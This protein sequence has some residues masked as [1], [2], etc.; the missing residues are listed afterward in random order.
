MN[1]L[2]CTFLFTNQLWYNFVGLI[3]KNEKCFHNSKKS[4]KDYAENGFKNFR[5]GF[6][7]VDILK[8]S[9]LYIYALVLF[10]VKNLN[11]Y[12]THTS[13]H[14]RNARLQN[15]LHIPSVKL[16]SIQTGVSYSSITIFDQLPWN[17]IKFHNNIH[18]FKTLLRNYLLKSAF[19]SI[20]E[21]LSTDHDS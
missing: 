21:F 20:E 19:C 1:G 11:I 13:I 14:G 18:I 10:A 2:F 3:I 6:K 4:N 7:K 5:E 15:E 9:C 16:P 17:I 8:V 12:Q